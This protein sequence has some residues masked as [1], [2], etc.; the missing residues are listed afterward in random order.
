MSLPRAVLLEWMGGVKM[1]TTR[2]QKEEPESLARGCVAVSRPGRCTQWRVR[3]QSWRRGLTPKWL[4]TQLRSAA[5]ARDAGRWRCAC[6]AMRGEELPSPL[7]QPH[8]P[9]L[10]RTK[11]LT[12]RGKNSGPWAPCRCVTVRPRTVRALRRAQAR[13]GGCVRSSCW[14]LV[15]AARDENTGAG[16]TGQR[17]ATNTSTKHKHKALAIG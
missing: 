2:G 13:G 8:P 9:L 12:S 1:P 4:G 17:K 3:K 14:F 10:V 7:P 6:H 15:S 5:A 11:P 16:G